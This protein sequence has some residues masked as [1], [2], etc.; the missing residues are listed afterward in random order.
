MASAHIPSNDHADSAIASSV[1]GAS[2]CNPQGT[3]DGPVD[4]P[5]LQ[6]SDE[7]AVI[8]CEMGTES[9]V[10]SSSLLMFDG[11]LDQ[12]L[13]QLDSARFDAFAETLEHLDC[14]GP[15]LRALLRRP[16]TWRC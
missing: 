8:L 14:P 9:V 6:A 16:L 1:D 13:F 7:T 4:R 5:A 12:R 11:L 2:A 3:I 10:E 15:K